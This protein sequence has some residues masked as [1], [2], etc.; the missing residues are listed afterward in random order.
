[1]QGS[2]LTLGLLALVLLFVIRMG[3]YSLQPGV[4]YEIVA[5]LKK[6]RQKQD[7]RA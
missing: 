6:R 1:M 4:S 3:K 7:S 5:H 2:T